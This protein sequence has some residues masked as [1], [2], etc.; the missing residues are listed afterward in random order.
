MIAKTVC[1]RAR[2]A[3]TP[4]FTGSARDRDTDS[5]RR[6]PFGASAS[7]SG[8]RYADGWA[9]VAMR[10]PMPRLETVERLQR[11]QLAAAERAMER[12]A[13]AAERRWSA[14]RHVVARLRFNEPARV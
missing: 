4:E 13:Q 6:F 8:I 5:C 11:R 14:R 10:L 9:R 12:A 3:K 2:A 1:I 7:A